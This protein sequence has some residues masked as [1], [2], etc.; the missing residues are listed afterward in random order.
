M[1]RL[2]AHVRRRL[3]RHAELQQ[4]LAVEVSLRTKWSVRSVDREMRWR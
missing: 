1:E 3:A 4:D 2:A